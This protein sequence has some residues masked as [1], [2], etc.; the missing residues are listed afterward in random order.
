MY[1]YAD[2]TD[3]RSKIKVK[4]VTATEINFYILT[5]NG[6]FCS[7][8]DVSYHRDM[9]FPVPNKDPPCRDSAFKL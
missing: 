9:D 6:Y 1:G 7:I 2:C 5:M 4:M 3:F 8:K